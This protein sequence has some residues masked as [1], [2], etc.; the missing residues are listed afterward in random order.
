M[1]R[2]IFI[3]F[4]VCQFV[5][6]SAQT[7]TNNTVFYKDSISSVYKLISASIN[8]DTSKKTFELGTR[9][10]MDSSYD[11]S[12]THTLGFYASTQNDVM[13]KITCLSGETKSAPI[14]FNLQTKNSGY[15]NKKFNIPTLSI[16]KKSFNYKEI[17]AIQVEVISQEDFL[18]DEFTF[19]YVEDKII[20]NAPGSLSERFNEEERSY[21]DKKFKEGNS[22]Y[23]KRKK[24]VQGR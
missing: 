6:T 19:Q 18:I 5:L 23:M 4:M 10:G 14:E 9:T 7:N 1:I 15:V 17:D 22:K 20:I 11:F 12:D 21:R 16:D 24:E 3:T 8:T 2:I 13:I